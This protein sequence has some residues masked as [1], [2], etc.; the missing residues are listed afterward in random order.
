MVVGPTVRD[1]CVFGEGSSW[2][3]AAELSWR[4]LSTELFRERRFVIGKPHKTSS[5]NGF[6]EP[7][8]LVTSAWFPVP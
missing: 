1:K 8:T 3:R 4:K 2:S 5:W 7:V 6:I